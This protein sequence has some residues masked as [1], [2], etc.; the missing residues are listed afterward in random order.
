[1]RSLETGGHSV[2]LKFFTKFG[3]IT[4]ETIEPVV[5]QTRLPGGSIDLEEGRLAGIRQLG[6]GCKDGREVITLD[7]QIYVGAEGYYDHIVIEGTP[8]ID[9]TIKDGLPGDVATAAMVVNSIPRVIHAEPGLITMK[10]LPPVCAASFR[11][12]EQISKSAGG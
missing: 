8:R 12:S 4:E 11:F 10:N 2:S 5:A 7:L 3:T 6:R 9:L 1:L